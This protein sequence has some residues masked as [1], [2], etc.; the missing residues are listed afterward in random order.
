MPK[1]LSPVDGR[2]LAKPES[3]HRAWLRIG[4][5]ITGAALVGTG[6][7][8]GLERWVRNPSCNDF[9]NVGA[10][11]ACVAHCWSPRDLRSR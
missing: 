8:L 1:P 2:W 11:R 4:P 9:V 5:L 7:L 10:H 6:G 3:Q